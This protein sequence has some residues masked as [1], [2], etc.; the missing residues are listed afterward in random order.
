MEFN[1][2]KWATRRGMLE[3]DLILG[4]FLDNVY[5]GLP[6]DDQQR[7]QQLLT[8]QDQDLYAWL[9]QRQDPEAPDMLR[10]V[11]IIRDHTGLKV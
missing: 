11:Q 5:L 9:M 4:P 8:E 7:F 2:I 1:Q 3:L 6:S 10:I